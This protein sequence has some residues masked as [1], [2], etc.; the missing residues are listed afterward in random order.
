MF[1]YDLAHSAW[2]TGVSSV[3]YSNINSNNQSICIFV[4]AGRNDGGHV[5]RNSGVE[6]GGGPPGIVS[7]S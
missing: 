5:V 1:L 2:M 4:G 7:V 6:D 3:N